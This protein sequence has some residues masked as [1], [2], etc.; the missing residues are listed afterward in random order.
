MKVGISRK[1]LTLIESIVATVIILSGVSAFFVMQ[2]VVVDEANTR[3]NTISGLKQA[4]LETYLDEELEE[5]ESTVGNKTAKEIFE[6]YLITRSTED[7]SRVLSLLDSINYEKDPLVNSSL[8]DVNG[9]VLVSSDPQME[10]KIRADQ[11]YF[12]N[13]KT[14]TY[15][16][17]DFE[18]SLNT[19]VLFFATP[20]KDEAGN[21]EA[22]VIK[23]SGLDEINKTVASRTGL[24]ITGETFLVNSSH[25]VISDLLKESGATYKKTIYLPQINLCL[26]GIPSFAE[27]VDY[28]GDT[29]YGYWKFIPELDSCL[30]VKIDKSE[31]LSP[32]KNILFP[33]LGIF[34]GIGLIGAILGLLFSR[35]LVRPIINLRDEAAKIRKG[36]FTGAIGVKSNDEIGD[37]A[38]AFSEMGQTIKASQTSLEKEVKEKTNQ[39]NA[40]LKELTE[41]Y[42]SSEKM[43]ELMIGRELSIIELKKKVSTLESEL[44]KK[45]P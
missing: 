14:K 10:G 34:V 28:H 17:L 23:R 19:P 12:I 37:L 7:K 45:N 40:K 44:A 21:L 30:S 5:F 42:S 8:L 29:V 43:N 27:R 33:F 9:N 25:L 39:L 1:I 15:M 16:G 18:V 32:L 36:D 22:V 4:S 11:K 26:E 38:V 35:S 20:L 2:K 13:G 41:L 6:N 24:G 3:L 31:V